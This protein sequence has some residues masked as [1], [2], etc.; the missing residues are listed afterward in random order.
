MIIK[1]LKLTNFRNHSTYQ[2]DCTDEISLILGP[3]GSGKTSVL[4]AIYLLT[5]TPI[6]TAPNSNFLAA[7]SLPQLT[8]APIKLSSPRI[9]NLV[10]SPAS[11]NIPL[12]FLSPLTLISFLTLPVVDVLILIVFLANSIPITPLHYQNTIKP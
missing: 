11:T 2:L 10:A 4:E 8:I 9:K 1:S 5:I 12:F 7:K 3:N 6:F